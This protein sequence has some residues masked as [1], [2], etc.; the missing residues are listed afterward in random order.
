[1]KEIDTVILDVG[2][3]LAD[4]WPDEYFARLGYDDETAGRL[5]KA[6]FESGH[7]H[8]YDRGVLTDEEVRGR[9]KALAPDLAAEI[10][11]SL[12]HAYDLVTKRDTAIPWIRSIKERG[13]RVYILSNF[14]YTVM[15]DCKDALD[16]V[17]YADG[18]FWSMEH[19]LIKPDAAIFLTLFY[20]YKI[21]PERAVF[22]DDTQANLD[23]A[24]KLGLRTILYRSQ[25]Q[26]QEELIRLLE[27]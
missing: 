2:G 18:C 9:F 23:T 15:E 27:K 10:D 6:T 12:I 26:A 22:I 21:D 1:M 24:Q 17:P 20:E 11:A 19:K 16:F 13:L 4:Y 3:V 25:Q 5:K 8:E 14:S 7:W